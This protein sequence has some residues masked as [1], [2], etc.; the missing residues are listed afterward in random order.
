V[1]RLIIERADGTL[2][3]EGEITPTVFFAHVESMKFNRCAPSV[4]GTESTLV[5]LKN[6]TEL[7]RTTVRRPE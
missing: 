5:I 2:Y 7:F 6:D 4:K 1:Y 3:Y